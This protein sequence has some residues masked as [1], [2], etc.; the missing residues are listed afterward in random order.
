MCNEPHELYTIYMAAC[1]HVWRDASPHASKQQ[2]AK[3]TG[4]ASEA[5]QV[6]QNVQTQRAKPAGQDDQSCK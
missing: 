2:Q 5:W 4:H 6:E 1:R 3:V